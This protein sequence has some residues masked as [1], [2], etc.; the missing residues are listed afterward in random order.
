MKILK[1]GVSNE[2]LPS[3]ISETESVVSSSP[4]TGDSNIFSSSI[5]F[6][7]SSAGWVSSVGE[8]PLLTTNFVD[9]TITEGL[10][11]IMAVC[12]I[13]IAAFVFFKAGGKLI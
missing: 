5:S 13:S 6:S 9:Y 1:G 12:V 4:E 2:L 7:D 11:L 10:L 8:R 3:S